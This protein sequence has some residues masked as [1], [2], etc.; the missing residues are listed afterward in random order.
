[1]FLIL[2]ENAAFANFFKLDCGHVLEARVSGKVH[3]HFGAVNLQV[4]YHLPRNNRATGRE[5]RRERGRE[6][7]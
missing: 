2:Q 5:G 1:M 4:G 6:G 3:S 7:G